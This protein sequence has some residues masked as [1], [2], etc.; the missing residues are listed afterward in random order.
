MTQEQK[1]ATAALVGLGLWLWLKPKGSTAAATVGG[2]DVLDMR[3]A[4]APAGTGVSSSGDCMCSDSE[5]TS[6]P[7]GC[8]EAY[9]QL[10]PL[11]AAPSYNGAVQD[12]GQP[13]GVLGAEDASLIAGDP[14]H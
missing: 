7:C 8:D 1:I 2:G 6:A 3:A 9:Q 11:V 13:I 10:P 4:G 5:G 14:A 12:T